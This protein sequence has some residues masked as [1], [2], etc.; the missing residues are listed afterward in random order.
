MEK[1]VGFLFGQAWCPRLLLILLCLLVTLAQSCAGDS[2]FAKAFS[3]ADRSHGSDKLLAD[4][5]RLD[6]GYPDRFVLKHEI[7][8]LYLQQG[9]PVAAAPYLERALSLARGIK[10]S[11]RATLYGG[12]A[13]VS[14]SRGD[15]PKAVDYGRTALDV[16]APE[17]A[18]FGFITGRA[19]L[20]QD[21]LKEALA[22][23]DAAWTAAKSSMS[24]DDYRAYARA[25]EAAGRDGDLVAVLDSYQSSFPY[26]PGLG[27]M[28]SAAYE[29][30]G[31]LDESVLAAFKE[32]EY[33]TAYG[34]S[35][36]S[37]VQK[38]LAAIGK[39]LGD[40]SF[41]PS[42]SGT[43]AWEAVTAFAK[44]DWIAAQRLLG[45][46]PGSSAFEKYLL[47]SSRIEAGNEGVTDLDAFA[48]LQPA[49]RSLP[50]Y[51]YRLY[52]AF[53]AL[54]GRSPDSL[55]DLLESAIDLAPRTDEAARYRREL[56]TVLGLAPADGPR[57]LTRAEL[58]AA[59]EKAAATGESGLLEPL[60]GTLE[61]RDNRTTLMAVGILRAFARDARHRP[62]FID[63]ACSARGRARERLEYILSH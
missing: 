45:R 11:D 10:A 15:Y 49:F 46:L 13:I 3:S 16:R 55:A 52:A 22:C 35:R 47:L 34:A 38:N 28:Q 4:L 20:A 63:Q 43:S 53:R 12:L 5:V 59:A 19:L 54:G 14:Y 23:L 7:G 31:D 42:G 29:R 61:L 26:E 2:A 24:P 8:L 33:A 57:L 60:V 50:P 44:G 41:N 32:A 6:Q 17:S 39:K 56:A 25:L 58:S 1:K 40:K 9:N 51:Y 30:L 18:P 36:A 62:Y 37:D 48:S 21:K 27:L